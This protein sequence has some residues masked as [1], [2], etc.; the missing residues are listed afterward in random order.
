MGNIF[1]PSVHHFPFNLFEDTFFIIWG[2]FRAQVFPKE[3]KGGLAFFLILIFV[4]WSLLLLILCVF[5]VFLLFWDAA[6]APLPLSWTSP[7]KN[8]SCQGRSVGVS[9]ISKEY[10]S[11]Y[12][13]LKQ[14]H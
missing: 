7:Y 1:A 8:T 11:A 12:K 3:K 14:K 5:V 9:K 13:T 2:N 4:F 10:K 6:D